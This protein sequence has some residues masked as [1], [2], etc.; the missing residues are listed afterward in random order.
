M[1]NCGMRGG[2][3]TNLCVAEPSQNGDGID[4]K[5]TSD[6]RKIRL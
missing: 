4:Q 1:M 6:V 2:R 5:H 3:A